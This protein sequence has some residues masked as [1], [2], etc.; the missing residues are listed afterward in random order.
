M[1][2]ILGGSLPDCPENCLDPSTSVIYSG[3]RSICCSC[4]QRNPDSR[5]RMVDIL[6]MLEDVW[7]SIPEIH[8]ADQASFH[9]LAGG[10]VCSSDFQCDACVANNNIPFEDEVASLHSS[11][12]D[13]SLLPLGL[14]RSQTSIPTLVSQPSLSRPVP[15]APPVT[16][17]DVRL[18]PPSLSTNAAGFAVQESPKPRDSA[19]GGAP[20]APSAEGLTF[21]SL[22]APLWERLLESGDGRK[23]R[24]EG[25][26]IIKQIRGKR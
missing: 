25:N 4:W 12:S 15:P 8:D 19:E 21:E 23:I 14:S 26:R 7:K 20:P 11:S 17:V 6:R 9:T 10:P 13:S 22:L 1:I 24:R 3:L 16:L 5:P 2:A 18:Q